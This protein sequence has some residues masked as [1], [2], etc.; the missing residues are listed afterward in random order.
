MI[1]LDTNSIIYLLVTSQPEH[2]RAQK[3]FAEVS[4]PLCITSTN[5]AEALRLLTHPRVFPKPLSLTKAVTLLGSFLEQWNVHILEEDP[6]WWQQLPFLSK[7]HS[8][9]K[10]NEV[11]DARIALC[12]RYNGVKELLTLD[13]NFEKYEFLKMVSF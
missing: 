2:L 13:R 7:A 8:G 9:L 4:S 5:I 1:G 12:L 10:G 3:W 6:S 11:F